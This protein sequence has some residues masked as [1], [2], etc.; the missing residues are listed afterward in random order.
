MSGEVREGERIREG[1]LHSLRKLEVLPKP[2][3]E[4]ASLAPRLMTK[5]S[6]DPLP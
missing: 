5:I 4:T 2:S 3:P 6:M 1:S